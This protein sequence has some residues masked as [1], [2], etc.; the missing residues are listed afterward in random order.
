[1]LLV[2]FECSTRLLSTNADLAVPES[3]LSAAGALLSCWYL[4]TAVMTLSVLSLFSP[5]TLSP[6]QVQALG[7]QM[8]KRLHAGLQPHE[9]RS[10][11]SGRLVIS[12]RILEDM[13]FLLDRVRPLGGAA[14]SVA[15]GPKVTSRVLQGKVSRHLGL[16]LAT[17]TGRIVAFIPTRQV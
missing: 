13:D 9:G 4:G 5:S 14:L 1:M 16:G 17:G 6:V 12:L 3:E 2:C 7:S 15:L 11:S 8:M 10:T